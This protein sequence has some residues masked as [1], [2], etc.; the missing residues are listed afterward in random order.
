MALITGLGVIVVSVLTAFFSRILAEEMGAWSPWIIRSLIKFAV[1]RLPEYRRERLDEE[2]QSH[3][4]DVP[5]QVGKLIAAVGFLFAAYDVTLDDQNN[6]M[7]ERIAHMLAQIDD[8]HSANFAIVNLIQSDEILS[9]REDLSSNVNELRSRLIDSQKSNSQLETLLASA[10]AT[11]QTLLK[12]LEFALGVRRVAASCERTL[13][14]VNKNR[15]VTAKIAKVL[16]ERNRR[17]GR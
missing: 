3:V 9:S 10:S 14:L 11:P 13:Q 12:K 5:G 6:Q 1:G 4:N 7:R 16:E 2:W 15:E 17:Q 8:A